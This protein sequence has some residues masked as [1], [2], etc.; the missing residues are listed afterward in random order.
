MWLVR[1]NFLLV[2]PNDIPDRIAAQMLITTIT[3]SA[4]IKAGHN[5][6]Y[7]KP[8]LEQTFLPVQIGPYT[9][10]HRHVTAGR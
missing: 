6:S 10:E 2:V 7:E 3:A 9:L 8:N 1:Y 4:L 5:A